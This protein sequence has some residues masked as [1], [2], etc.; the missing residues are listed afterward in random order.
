V[1]RD[2]AILVPESL[3]FSAIRDRVT[4]VASG[5]LRELTVFDIYRGPG[6]EPGLKSLALGLIFQEKSRTLTD[7]ETDG[8]IA[9]IRADLISTLNARTRE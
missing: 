2:L 7:V 4:L 1:R 8:L 5:R 9:D 3:P 6:V